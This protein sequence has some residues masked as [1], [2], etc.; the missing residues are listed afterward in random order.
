[1]RYLTRFATLVTLLVLALA[2]AACT[3]V[4]SSDSTDASRPAIT[5]DESPVPD[6]MPVMYEFYTLT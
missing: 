5:P 2:L 1:M 6:G 3:T 4:T